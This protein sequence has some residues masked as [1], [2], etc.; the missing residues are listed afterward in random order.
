MPIADTVPAPYDH[1]QV[2]APD[3]TLAAY[4]L[5]LASL[6]GLRLADAVALEV[7]RREV[8]S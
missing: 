8:V 4:A 6:E 3:E 1:G 2:A 5:V 7:L